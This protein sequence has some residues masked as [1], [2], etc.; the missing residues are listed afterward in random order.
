MVLVLPIAVAPVT[1]AAL[2]V[3]ISVISIIPEPALFTV[4]DVRAVP[5]PIAPFAVTFAVPEDK[6]RA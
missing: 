5:L 2:E 3:P 1:P 4:N 6:V